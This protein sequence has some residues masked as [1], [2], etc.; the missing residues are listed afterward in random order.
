MCQFKSAIVLREPR[1]KSGFALIHSF[2]TDSHSELIAAH[3]L[4]D[5]GK[6]R[7]ARVEFVPQTDDW[8]DL[9]KYKLKIDEERT[10][11]WF[12]KDMQEAVAEK[13]LGIVQSMIVPKE[14]DYLLGGS[15]IIPQDR[16]VHVGPNTLVVRNSGTVTDNY[17]TVTRNSGTVTR[18]SGTVTRNSGTVT[19]NYGT[20]TD[21]SGTVTDNYGTVTRNSGTVTDNYGTVTDNSGTVT[22]NSGTVTDNY[23]TVTRNSGT[24]TRNYGTVTRNSGTVQENKKNERSGKM[25]KIKEGNKPLVKDKK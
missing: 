10:P 11:D 25:G 8:T 2:A 15:W 18:N 21:N 22:R 16:E 6:L 24:V 12:D 14:A 17:G 4:R 1:D 5:D 13:M 7:F 20:V 19:R 9:K 23:G 3:K